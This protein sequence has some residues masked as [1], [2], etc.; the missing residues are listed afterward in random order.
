MSFKLSYTLDTVYYEREA[1][2]TGLFS[3]VTTRNN[4]RYVEELSGQ[5]TFY[6]DD[7]DFIIAAGS[8]TEIFIECQFHK[9]WQGVFTHTDCAIINRSKK[10]LEV[11]P[12]PDD[13]YSKFEPWMGLE[14]NIVPPFEGIESRISVYSLNQYEIETRTIRIT[15]P[16]TGP[17]FENW[18]GY[19][20]NDWI[21]NNGISLGSYTGNN[22]VRNSLIWKLTNSTAPFA[23]NSAADAWNRLV[24]LD[25]LGYDLISA[26]IVPD[27]FNF[28]NRYWR[29]SLFTLAEVI[30]IYNDDNTWQYCDLIYRRE[31]YNGLS[32]NPPPSGLYWTVS[33][34]NTEDESNPNL[35]SGR[36]VYHVAD[37]KWVR[38]LFALHQNGTFVA[39]GQTVGN[40][41]TGDGRDYSA[42]IDTVHEGLNARKQ[43]LLWN[44]IF[45]NQYGNSDANDN[46]WYRNLYQPVLYMRLFHKPLTI[47]Q[48]FIEFIRSEGSPTS[49][50]KDDIESRFFTDTVN[51]Y[52]GT[53]N[54]W[55]KVLIGQNSDVK[56]PLATESATKEIFT[57]ESFLDM[58]CGM[59]N[60][61][62]AIIDGKLVI[63]HIS[64][65]EKGLTYGQ[66]SES[67]FILNP[68][69]IENIAKAK[70]FM[71]FT[72]SYSYDKANMQKYEI[73]KTTGGA[74]PEHNNTKIEYTSACVNNRPKEN[75]KE[76]TFDTTTDYNFI[77]ADGSDAGVT[78]MLTE[79]YTWPLPPN[80]VINKF[81]PRHDMFQ[82]FVYNANFTLQSVIRKYHSWGR[83][84]ESALLNKVIFEP[85]QPFKN[86]S[87]QLS[88]PF[89]LSSPEKME[90]PYTIIMTGLGYG[91]INR[92][93][94]ETKPGYVTYELGL[95]EIQNVLP[96]EITI[97]WHVHNQT[98]PS[99]TWDITHEM[100][101]TLIMRPCIFDSSGN[102]IEYESM[103]ILATNRIL[104]RFT[105]PISGEVHLIAL[106]MPASRVFTGNALLS[107]FI[108]VV[109]DLDRVRQM[110]IGPVIDNL[111]HEIKPDS[112]E[113]NFDGPNYV[114]FNFTQPVT[115]SVRIADID[116][117]SYMTNV[118]VESISG[119]NEI[120]MPRTDNFVYAKP[121][122]LKAGAE[123]M[124]N[125]HALIATLRRIGFTENV[126]ASIIVMEKQ[127]N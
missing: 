114:R 105:Q 4:H 60:C 38:R 31:I 72:D 23:Q 3:L 78:L 18:T 30:N 69:S 44:R 70:G 86:I 32:E 59:S 29:D 54:D 115:A 8:C 27:G 58:I 53:L 103:V 81:F 47:I 95:N 120:D 12:R 108:D 52:T 112:I 57:F 94:Y 127:K 68:Y 110:G 24:W 49:I 92:S 35:T 88:F 87:Q 41:I 22:Q 75:I 98:S 37:K 84:N 80:P 85:L 82:R 65:F 28:V 113:Y 11:V 71:D 97:D 77:K 90:N 117:T 26:D 43:V 50:T 93:E 46:N 107:N 45:V 100:N 19:S 111:G 16:Y 66:I 89:K 122:I 56:R 106:N 1:S 6:G 79:Y 116:T 20:V 126:I 5:M 124:Y 76:I 104:I 15:D 21:G 42:L 34:L 64:Y 118:Y 99:D 61:A 125:S 119:D 67:E 7:Y 91:I 51:P 10:F 40:L 36:W 62:W 55:D 48:K 17:G 109:H 74:E 9:V 13:D 63:E 39:D 101:N 25:P 96:P 14:F 33:Q 121:I 123:I 83:N 2:P 73:F 102:E